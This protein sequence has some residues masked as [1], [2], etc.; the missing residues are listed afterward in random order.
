MSQDF[1]QILERLRHCV[2]SAKSLQGFVIPADIKS[3]IASFASKVEAGDAGAI[4]IGEAVINALSKK[5]GG[6]IFFSVTDRPVDGKM[7]IAHFNKMFASRKKE[8]KYDKDIL[9]KLAAKIGELVRAVNSQSALS[10]WDR[11][12]TYNRTCT[13]FE[14]AD[15]MQKSRDDNRRK[16]EFDKKTQRL[17]AEAE[18]ATRR[19]KKRDSDARVAVIEQRKGLAEEI[20]ELIA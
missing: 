11:V 8:E 10:L 17:A 20:R 1:D 18:A 2:A 5:M 4:G 6:F 3:F 9:D 15:A 13:A 14:E 19:N 7:R 16:R 12:A